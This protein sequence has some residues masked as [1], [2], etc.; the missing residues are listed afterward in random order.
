V[1]QIAEIID[2]LRH[3]FEAGALKP[4]AIEIVPFEKAVEAYIRMAGGQAKVKQVLSFD[5]QSGQAAI[6][7]EDKN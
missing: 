3:R 1:Q 4:P 5:G 6:S 2:G 7:F